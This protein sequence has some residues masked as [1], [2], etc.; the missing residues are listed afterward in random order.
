MSHEWGGVI[1]LGILYPGTSYT[2]AEDYA[3]LR[4]AFDTPA[5]PIEGGTLLKPSLIANASGETGYMEL[6]GSGE[7]AYGRSQVGRY[8]GPSVADLNASTLFI[9][10]TFTSSG[11][12]YKILKL[13]VHLT[14]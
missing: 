11:T 6:D 8:I 13:P 10:R 7:E 3:K 5:V 12:D 2:E 9:S 14:L 1:A 4:Y